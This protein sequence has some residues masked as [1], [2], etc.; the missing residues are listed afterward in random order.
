MKL[1]EDTKDSMAKLAAGGL[2]LATKKMRT[3]RKKRRACMGF[4]SN[5]RKQ[6][7]SRLYWF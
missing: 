5:L 6:D 4:T 3:Q 2:R 7:I 1:I